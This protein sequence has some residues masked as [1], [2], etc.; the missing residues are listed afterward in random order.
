MVGGVLFNLGGVPHGEQ[1]Q[2]EVGE[3]DGVEG[4][5]PVHWQVNGDS[6]KGKHSIF[7]AWF[8][9]VAAFLSSWNEAVRTFKSGPGEYMGTVQSEAAKKG[10][11]H[12]WQFFFL[13]LR[14]LFGKF[15][16]F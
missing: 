7:V 8:F 1:D 4:N 13:D 11:M 12:P 6:E 16:K 3:L 2:A 14:D 9:T 5:H 10:V 15:I